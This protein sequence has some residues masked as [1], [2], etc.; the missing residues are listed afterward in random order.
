[1]DE[2]NERVKDV[3]SGLY[4]YLSPS[5]EPQTTSHRQ[6]SVSDTSMKQH[7]APSEFLSTGSSIIADCRTHTTI[8]GREEAARPNLGQ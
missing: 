5:R 2:R 1:M 7:T 6:G 4:I 3:S 8:R